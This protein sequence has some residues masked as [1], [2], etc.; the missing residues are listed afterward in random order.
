V[1]WLQERYQELYA[2]CRGTSLPI[3]L[4][5][6]SREY[7]EQLALYAQGR[8][9]LSVVNHLRANANMPLINDAE[10]KIVT[11][12]L[13]S[14]HIINDKRRLSE[15]F[16]IGIVKY[17]GGKKELEWNLKADIN[18]DQLADW[19]EVVIIGRSLGLICGAD[20]KNKPDWGHFETPAHY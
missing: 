16:D 14:K 17:V 8:E 11:W 5:C 2:I 9:V 6:T 12:T 3:M 1:P 19:E 7:L 20:F 18:D 10:N 15:A 4:L 13:D